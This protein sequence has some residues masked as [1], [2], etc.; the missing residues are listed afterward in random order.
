MGTSLGFLGSY[1]HYLDPKSQV[2][3][4]GLVYRYST[5]KSQVAAAF[6]RTSFDED[7]QRLGGVLGYAW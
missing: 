1:L 6:A 7:R 5:T 4:F 3:M 2:S